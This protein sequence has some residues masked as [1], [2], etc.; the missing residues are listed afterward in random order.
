MTLTKLQFEVRY[1]KSSVMA[2]L[3][4]GGGGGMTLFLALSSNLV[5][6]SLWT[7]WTLHIAHA[8]CTCA[9]EEYLQGSHD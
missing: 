2:P 7:S 1:A 5:S 4:A 8:V 3:S 6:L 9:T